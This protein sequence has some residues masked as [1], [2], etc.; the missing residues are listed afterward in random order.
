M[1]D[2][3]TLTDKPA[4][5][6]TANKSEK[7]L[8]S[9]Q[10]K[11][12][13]VA[14]MKQG[15]QDIKDGKVPSGVSGRFGKLEIIDPAK[16]KEA[17]KDLGKPFMPLSPETIDKLTGKN[18]SDQQGAGDKQAQGVPGKP[19][20]APSDQDG[21]Q[22]QADNKTDA[23][24]QATDKDAEGKPQPQAEVENYYGKKPEEASQ[25]KVLKSHR[26]N[27]G[28]IVKE[29][30][31]GA[32]E[33]YNP[34]DGSSV[35]VKPDQTIIEKR[36]DGTVVQTDKDGAVTTTSKDG[37]VTR[38]DETGVTT[39]DEKSGLVV[40]QDKNGEVT[41]TVKRS[42]GVYET[43]LPNGDKR[44]DMEGNKTIVQHKDGS[45]D[46]SSPETGRRSYKN[47]ELQQ[48]SKYDK[49][50]NS[51]TEYPDGSRVTCKPD[52]TV[53]TED[54]KGNKSTL[55]PNKVLVDEKKDGTVVT[56]GND[57]S[58]YTVHPDGT[59]TLEDGQ[60]GVRKLGKDEE[61]AYKLR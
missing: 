18:G 44:F 29:Y 32:V 52:R 53:I 17:A 25:D 39:V 60:G 7:A 33:Q 36:K 48:V 11:E 56:Y 2:Q 13:F 22:K 15:W 57:K 5:G 35:T 45:Y 34:K 58:V 37:I 47:G 6:A 46:Y 42:D 38:K 31:S 30:E 54:G 41:K 59:K 61:I 23:K 43:T 10:E 9:N 14:G 16:V 12:G 40:H 21:Q 28:T 50:G 55:Y 20:D 8:V 19:G 3:A 51:V 49:D 26:Q 4:E 1:S 24:P 27:D